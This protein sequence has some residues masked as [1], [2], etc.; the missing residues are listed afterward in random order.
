MPARLLAAGVLLVCAQGTAW[1]VGAADIKQRQ[2]L[3]LTDTIFASVVSSAGNFNYMDTEE[4]ISIDEVTPDG[5]TYQIKP[6]A[7]G[8]QKVQSVAAKLRWP[9]HVRREDLENSTRVTLLTASTD[10]KDYA[11]QTFQ[12]TSR[13]VL[14]TLKASGETP[15]T[16]GVYA[17][18]DSDPLEGIA[19]AAA[20]Q[21]PS[22]Q[23]RASGAPLLPDPGQIFH[24]LFGSA[25]RYYRGTLHRVEPQDVPVAVIV[26]GVRT[27]LPA[28]HAAGDFTFGQDKPVKVEVWWLDNPDWPLSLHWQ[29]GE[30]STQI[31]KIDWA[32]SGDNGPGGAGARGTPDGSGMAEQLAGKSCRVELHGVYFDSGSAV[33]LEESEPMLKQ[34]AQL[35]KSSHDA[36]LTIEG[37]TDNIG[38]ADYNQILSEQRAAAVRDALVNRY[39]I[40]A[41]R[42]TA[43][44]YGLTRPVD[45]NTTVVGRAHNRRVELAR[46]CAEH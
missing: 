7:P 20:S 2:G 35:V 14:M 42:L 39:A 38:S 36:T 18:G 19:A 37:H 29:F 32:G 13:K 8:N 45:S 12:E 28:V 27:E 23:P 21:K 6:S 30:G 26:N 4:H 40:P 15:L 24:M 41:N 33:L 17:G 22:S 34:V 25:R 31:T 16:I 43:K 46:P 11:G 10:P 1:A 44:G 9:R 3:V 5:L